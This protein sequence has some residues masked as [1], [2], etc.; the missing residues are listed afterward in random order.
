MEDA[1]SIQTYPFR[2]ES[3][4][5]EERV[6]DLLQRL[7]LDEKFHMLTGYTGFTTY[8][9][10]RLGVPEFGMTDG[11]HGAGKHSAFGTKNTYFPASIGLAASWDPKMANAYGIALAEETRAVGRHCI[12]APGFNICRTP[13]NG[14]TF[15]YFSEDPFLN[16]QMINPLV[17][18]IQS[19]RIAACLKHFIANNTDI[20]R[21]FSN[22]IIDERTLEEIYF[23]AFKSVV[24][25][26]D[27]WSIMGS[28]NLLNGK[29]VYE[30]IDLLSR[31]VCGEWG[32]KNVIISDWT[33]THALRNPA[34]CIKAKFSLEMPK[35]FVYDL[36]LLH[37]A[38]ANK[39]FS[40]EELNDV[41]GRLLRTMFQV[42][43]FDSQDSIP[44]GSRN[45]PEHQALACKMAEEGFVLLKND[46]ATLPILSSL[47]KKIYL[48]GDMANYHFNFIAYG[49]SSGVVPPFALSVKKVISNYLAP[50]QI[51]VKNP[52]D[53]DISIVVTGW[54]HMFYNDAEG[55]DRRGLALSKRKVRKIKKV[56]KQCKNTVVVLYGGSACTM[57]DW[58]MDVKALLA[59]WQP[60]QMAGKAICNILFG[61]ANPSGKLPI[62]FPKQLEDSPAH[63]KC[64]NSNLNETY[65]QFKY[66][67]LKMIKHELIYY[68][69]SVERNIKPVD[70]KYSEGIY[71]GYRHFDTRDIEPLFPFGH[72]LSYT[73]FEYLSANLDKETASVG[74][75]ILLTVS[76]KNIGEYQGKEI[77]QVY[78]SQEHPNID[79]PT[80][81][82]CGFAKVELNPGEQRDVKISI[83]SI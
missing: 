51:L 78:Y 47:Y 21:K 80:K 43:L 42:G 34:T 38:F 56:S 59:A 81:E 14:R 75:E 76:I 31:R 6:D 8:P 68:K 45:T 64:Y 7:T 62:S 15:E 70:V 55:E 77:I 36:D 60:H 82:L 11:P 37:T 20:V 16:K 39:E 63:S 66:S 19:K 12:L 32:F 44:A 13:M 54:T 50:D 2:D 18:G 17:Q 1:K 26:S 9:I 41:V 67:V 22:S 24:E 4:S 27:P 25:Q 71:V 40:E 28:Y 74:D 3:L 83:P 73:Q 57:D 53:A 29:Y 23:P 58:V 30:D 10:P 65:P 61:K 52:K 35:P 49:G 5:L 69:N 48:G 46:G 72:G 33:A 79:R